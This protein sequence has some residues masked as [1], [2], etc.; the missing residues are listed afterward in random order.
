MRTASSGE[1]DVGAQPGA[2]LAGSGTSGTQEPQRAD[3]DVTPIHQGDGAT[4]SKRTT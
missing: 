1:A 2:G 4:A 3:A